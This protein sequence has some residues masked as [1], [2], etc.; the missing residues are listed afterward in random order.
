MLAEFIVVITRAVRWLIVALHDRADDAERIERADSRAVQ[1]SLAAVH[2]P[3]RDLLRRGESVIPL[4]KFGRSLRFTV[5]T[6]FNS[7][8]GAP[9]VESAGKMDDTLCVL[10]VSA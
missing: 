10:P 1:E 7:D 9:D 6:K 4:R 2:L 5:G 3:Q 8:D